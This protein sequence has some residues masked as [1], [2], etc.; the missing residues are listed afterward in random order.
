M[1]AT[2][3]PLVMTAEDYHRDYSRD[4]NSSLKLFRES[5][6]RYA[7]IRVHGSM[8]PDLPTPAMELGTQLHTLVLE[9]VE[10]LQDQ[11]AIGGPVNP[12]TGKPYGDDTKAFAEWFQDQ[13]KARGMSADRFKFLAAM[14]DGVMRNAFARQ[15]I[16]A[17]GSVEYRIDWDDAATGLP[18]KLRADKVTN[19]GLIGDLKTTDDITPDAFGRSV[20]NFEYHCQAALYLAGA[21]TQGIGGPFVF[22][23]VSKTPPHE[24]ATYVLDPVSLHIGEQVN[25]KTLA[26]LLIRRQ[27]GDWSGRWSQ[28]LYTVSLP[29]WAVKQFKE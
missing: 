11:Y 20:F 18:L 22:V 6:E 26:E 16:E 15:V 23:V 5:V 17:P 8:E 24:C 25:D 13:G 10:A 9:G 27:S 19:R 1:I 4:S 14:R 2:C 28:D 29:A 7:A 21:Q 3:E 12:K